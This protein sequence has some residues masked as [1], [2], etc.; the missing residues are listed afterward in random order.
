MKFIELKFEDFA[1]INNVLEREITR[2][3]LCSVID[4]FADSEKIAKKLQK[5]KDKIQNVLENET[6]EFERKE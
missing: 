2:I 6:A 5:I 3:K 4:G 1:V